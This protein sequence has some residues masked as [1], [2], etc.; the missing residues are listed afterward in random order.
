[1][2]SKRDSS[3]A[4]FTP[5]IHSDTYP[6]IDPTQFN[7][8]NTAVFITGASKGCGRSTALS[9]ARAGCSHIALGARSSM[10]DLE[11]ELLAAAKEAGK[12][13][14][15]ILLLEL[16]VTSE[17]NV[18]AAAK[19]ISSEFGR[20]DI[21]INNA[22]YASPF[23]SVMEENVDSW[24]RTWE[25]NIKGPFLL[26]QSFIP[27]LL[28]TASGLKTI[29]NVSSIGAHYSGPGS[30]YKLSKLALLRFGEMIAAEHEREGVV[31]FGIHPGA[32]PTELASNLPENMRH[33]LQD[34]PELTGNSL[35]W[36]SKEKRAWLNGRYV[37][38]TWD[39]EELEKMRAEIEDG[40]LLKVR[41]DVE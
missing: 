7:L 21:L 22:G 10:K 1:M 40:N 14:P 24:W 19:E 3:G 23:V 20:L 37:S 2:S 15:H 28:S 16:D 5:T 41:M 36:L 29:I 25:V 34:S 12:E 27:L 39:M 38:C 35:V 17:S 31:C 13:P 33:K 18:A 30:A 8:S 11:P 9:Y 32:V 4:N 6:F 26:T